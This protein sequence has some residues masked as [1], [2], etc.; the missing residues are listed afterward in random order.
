LENLKKEH[1]FNMR[2]HLN[3]KSI[4]FFIAL[5]VGLAVYL[6]FEHF[7]LKFTQ[8]FELDIQDC[9]MKRWNAKIAAASEDIALIGVD[10]STFL[11][12]D[13]A[14]PPRTAF[15]KLVKTLHQSGA[16]TIALDF[17]FD[18]KR[19]G[20]E[21]LADI[22]KDKDHLIY[23]VAVDETISIRDNLS[24]PLPRLIPFLFRELNDGRGEN[25][26]LAQIPSQTLRPSIKHL[27]HLMLQS[28]TDGAIRHIPLLIKVGEQYY[29]ALSLIA[30]CVFKDVPLNSRGITVKW[31]K[32]ILLDNQKGWLRKIPIDKA[33]RMRINYIGDMRRFEGS[34][35]FW[36]LERDIEADIRLD[37]WRNLFSNKLV[38][39]G[40]EE[41]QADWTSTPFSM[42]FPG[43]AVHATAIDNMLRAEFVAE[44][45][46][47]LTICVVLCLSGLM[48]G[49]Q[50]RV[51]RS[52][53]QK[54]P[55]S[56]RFRAGIGFGIF[57]GITLVY[58]IFA[59]SRFYFWGRF[60]NFLS[61]LTGMLITWMFATYYCHTDFVQR[62]HEAQQRYQWELEQAYRIQS[63]LMPESAPEIP[64]I[65]LAGSC[66]PA[67]E[68]SGDFYTYFSS[69]PEKG[70]IGV[71]IADVSGKSLQGAMIGM[72]AHGMLLQ[73][74]AEQV[75][76]VEEVL[77]RLN[78]QLFH[79]T[80]KRTFVCLGLLKVELQKRQ[81]H[82]ACAGQWPPVLW[83]Q[84]KKVPI[85]VEGM[86]LGIRLHSRYES[87]S[88][89]LQ[90]KDII[91][92]F[93]DG[94]IEAQNEAE[95]FYGEERLEGML[96]RLD[97]TFDAAQILKAISEDLN[98]FRGNAPVSDDVTI[99]VLVVTEH[100]AAQA[101]R[102]G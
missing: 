83:R 99:V 5:M 65:S 50:L 11:K 87:I 27:G 2:F 23:G 85:E 67:A 60:G 34:Y 90:P 28:S 19:K 9:L 26:A 32:Y 20:T 1:R 91:V 77:F 30:V 48:V 41:N 37:A 36:N 51:L 78:E 21:A 73:A 79:T 47:A 94:L 53:L 93:T 81:M 38:L 42:K 66:Q 8:R 12:Y 29:P 17:T 76:G 24:P 6:F 16:Q 95:A 96:R 54:Q 58:V 75:V 43:V 70:Q 31:G 86:P 68:T 98:T 10:E 39:I 13:G 35:S 18:M 61:P 88:L 82:I 25:Y 14:P 46:P 64:G 69:Q 22:S 52:E 102:D 63:L 92:S 49:L 56:Y 84:G 7:V 4:R 55:H 40:S 15:A 71:A 80:D 89:Q 45:S 97:A 44:T 101:P 100:H 33:G 74:V 3:S 72:M 62:Q 57:V 59:F